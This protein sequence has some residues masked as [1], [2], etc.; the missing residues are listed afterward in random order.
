MHFVAC[1]CCLVPAIWQRTVVVVTDDVHEPVPIWVLHDSRVV[2]ERAKELIHL[3]EWTGGLRGFGKDDGARGRPLAEAASIRKLCSVQKIPCTVLSGGQVLHRPT[4]ARRGPVGVVQPVRRI[5]L[6]REFTTI[7]AAPPG[8][9]LACP[10]LTLTVE[11]AVEVILAR[12]GCKSGA[13]TAR[14][15]T[16]EQTPSCHRSRRKP[17]ESIAAFAVRMEWD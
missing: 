17:I 2:V 15:N 11:R 9:A 6:K 7:V 4:P 13:C 10:S 5:R 1:S 12:V 8:I 16:E 14:K 3:L